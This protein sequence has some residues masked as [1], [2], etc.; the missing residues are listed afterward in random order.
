M[1]F[2]GIFYLWKFQYP[3]SLYNVTGLSIYEPTI[4]LNQLQLRTSLSL[5]C[6]KEYCTVQYRAHQCQEDRCGMKVTLENTHK[7]ICIQ[8]RNI[9]GDVAGKIK[10]CQVQH[11]SFPVLRWR[12]IV[13]LPHPLRQK[14]PLFP[15]NSLSGL[16][17][18]CNQKMICS[19]IY[20][21]QNESGSLA[22]KWQSLISFHRTLSL[23]TCP[24]LYFVIK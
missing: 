23:M 8:Q 12:L 7:M 13:V 20:V 2:Q 15:T 10:R 9:H 19:V 24:L 5:F 22:G 21:T 1:T 4:R 14:I 17:L 3:S 11:F 6:H 18:F 16:L